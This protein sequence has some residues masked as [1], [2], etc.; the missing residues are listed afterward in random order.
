MW[1]EH[2]TAL[3]DVNSLA[4]PIALK[5]DLMARVRLCLIFT[6]GGD[7]RTRPMKLTT[8]A[9]TIAFAF[10]STFAFAEGTLNYS[11]FAAHPIVRGVT[12]PTATMP[13]EILGNTMRDESSARVFRASVNG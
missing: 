4:T 11:T 3:S 8:I 12:R 13:R 1:R 7:C 5:K 6:N 9:L 10:P 2:C